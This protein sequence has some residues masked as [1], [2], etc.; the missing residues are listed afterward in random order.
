MPRNKQT[1]KKSTQAKNRPVI[2]TGVVDTNDEELGGQ[3]KPRDLRATGPAIEALDPPEPI[4]IAGKMVSPEKAAE[5][6]FNE[7]ILTV[8]VHESTDVNDDP[9]PGVWINGISQFFLRGIEQN[10]KRKF[11]GALARAKKTVYTQQRLPDNA[12]YRQIGHTR[13]ANPF[14]VIYDP[15]GAKGVA[16]LKDALKQA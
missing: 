9:M 14:Q 5:L 15:S 10:V 4:I 6:A 2:S 16:W 3:L 13:L 11:V 8:L 12:G 7:E 1:P